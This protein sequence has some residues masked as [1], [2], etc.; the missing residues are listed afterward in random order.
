[1]SE[2]IHT[3]IER[4][5]HFVQAGYVRRNTKTARV[6]SFR[7]CPHDINGQQRPAEIAIVAL[8][9]TEFYNTCTTVGERRDQLPSLISRAHVVA[10]GSVARDWEG[11]SAHGG[12][13]RARP[14]YMWRCV[15]AVSPSA[16]CFTCGKAPGG[17]PTSRSVVMPAESN[18]MS[19]PG[20]IVPGSPANMPR[21]T[22]T[23]VSIS[24]GM[25]VPPRALMTL[26]PG[27]GGGSPLPTAAMRSP[28]TTT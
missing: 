1:M 27:D 9:E 22:C 18:A 10:D 3:S 21:A 16:I 4:R 12:N 25:I 14:Y 28:S 8:L 5:A 6:R 15:A 17:V 23:C 19:S 13:Q 20:S 24:P 11:I 7:D 2:V 26:A